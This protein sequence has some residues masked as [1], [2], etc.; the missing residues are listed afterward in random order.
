L[1]ALKAQAKRLQQSLAETG[2]S[3]HHSQSLELLAKQLGFRDWNTLCAKAGNAMTPLINLGQSITGF[4]MGKPFSGTIIRARDIQQGA[5]TQITVRFDKPVN[6]SKFESMAVER[7]Q[8]SA[9]IG[10]D[11]RT[12]E[13]TSDGTPHMYVTLG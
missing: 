7:R 4:Y 1:D 8:V 10:R 11:G 6:V 2:Q 3:V 9:I 5:K 12:L 13:K